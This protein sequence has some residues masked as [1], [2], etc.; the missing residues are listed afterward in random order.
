[1]KPKQ[2]RRRSL[3]SRMFTD[4]KLNYRVMSGSPIVPM[5]FWGAGAIDATNGKSLLGA[6]KLKFG[7]ISLAE[8]LAL[9]KNTVLLT[10]SVRDHLCG[11][12]EICEQTVQ[13]VVT[14]TTS[15]GTKGRSL[16]DKLA[17]RL[18]QNEDQKTSFEVLFSIFFDKS[19]SSDQENL[20]A[21]QKQVQLAT[22]KFLG[23]EEASSAFIET[24]AGNLRESEN[25]LFTELANK[26][27]EQ[28]MEVG[29]IDVRVSEALELNSGGLFL[30]PASAEGS[31]ASKQNS[32]WDTYGPSLAFGGHK[33]AGGQ[34][35]MT[36]GLLGLFVAGCSLWLIQA[37]KKMQTP[38]KKEMLE[39]KFVAFQDAEKLQGI[40]N[41]EDEWELEGGNRQE[42]LRRQLR[43]QQKKKMGSVSAETNSVSSSTNDGIDEPAAEPVEIHSGIVELAK[44][45][46][47]VSKRDS[48]DFGGGFADSAAAF[49]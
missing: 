45:S 11:K 7:D 44:P 20:S 6:G 35:I 21:L 29:H 25:P 34:S 14:G 39:E 19:K 42:S 8:M 12:D 38:S 1:M 40:V 13:V 32:M 17:S 37:A 47:K 27:K 16:V 33:S 2:D 4:R 24:L 41:S 36:I 48:M 10:N 49:Q 43:R 18:L 28:G 22:L 15:S 5:Q 30:A 9:Q 23:A 46:P 26:I 31:E 3:L